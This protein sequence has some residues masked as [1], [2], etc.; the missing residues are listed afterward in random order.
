MK[1]L[2]EEVENEGMVKLIGETVTLFCMNYFYNG[3]LIGVNSD[4][5]LLKNPKLIYET[6]KWSDSDWRDAQ[7][8]GIEE[9]YVRIE[10][11]ESYAVTK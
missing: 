6:G 10:A 9:L 11:I 2:V 1:K 8:M 5:V 3:K 4:C 7:S